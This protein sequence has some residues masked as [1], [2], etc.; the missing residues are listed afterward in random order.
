LSEESG[1]ESDAELKAALEDASSPCYPKRHDSQRS[2]NQPAMLLHRYP[3]KDF[4]DP[5]GMTW[6]HPY[7]PECYAAIG[8]AL[9]ERSSILSEAFK[10]IVLDCDN[11]LWK[12]VC[13][14]T[15]AGN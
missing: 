1:R 9:S 6:P 3:I 15:V 8:T 2:R 10:V 5:L 14:R 4:Y 11:T 7:T 12:G 13:A